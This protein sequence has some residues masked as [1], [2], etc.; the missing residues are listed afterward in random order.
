MGLNQ[1]IASDQKVEALKKYPS[2]II[3]ELIVSRRAIF[4]DAFFDAIIPDAI[5]VVLVLFVSCVRFN[6]KNATME[7]TINN[8][9]NNKTAFIYYIVPCSKINDI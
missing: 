8:N 4:L 7:T 1:K 9:D 5:F 6:V 3:F 2:T